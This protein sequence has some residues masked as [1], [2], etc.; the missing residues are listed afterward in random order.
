MEGRRCGQCGNGG[1]GDLEEQFLMVTVRGGALVGVTGGGCWGREDFRKGFEQ[2]KAGVGD[3]SQ[4][5]CG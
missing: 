5:D 2:V 4:N 3:G 1:I